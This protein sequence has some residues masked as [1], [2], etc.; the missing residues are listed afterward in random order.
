MNLIYFILFICLINLFHRRHCHCHCYSLKVVDTDIRV[1]NCVRS[2]NFWDPWMVYLK[3]RN[4]HH[5]LEYD[6]E[7]M[8]PWTMDGRPGLAFRYVH[9]TFGSDYETKYHGII[10]TTHFT[11]TN[12]L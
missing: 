6:G 11:T 8:D 12:T 10:T 2:G 7:V 3:R 5:T 1:A 9:S 4:L